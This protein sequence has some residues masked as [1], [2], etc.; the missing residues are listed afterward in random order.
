VSNAFL[1][2]IQ[3][4]PPCSDDILGIK[5][6]DLNPQKVKIDN[7]KRLSHVNLNCQNS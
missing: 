4:A 7:F 2:E 5:L 1:R 3:F 6:L